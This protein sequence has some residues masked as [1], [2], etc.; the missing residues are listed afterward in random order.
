MFNAQKPSLEELPSSKQL[1]RSTIAAIAAAIV[2]L[3]VVV[4]PAEYG[5]DPTGVGR[6]LGLTEMG[7]IKNEL[8]EEAEQDRNLNTQTGDQ[9]G[10]LRNVFGLFVSSAHAQTGGAWTDEVEFTL[11]PGG[12]YEV[13][14]TMEEGESVDYAMTVTGGRVNFDLHGHGNGNSTTYEKG[15]GSQGSEGT[16]TAAFQGGHGWFWRNRDSTPLTVTLK[17]R[18]TYSDIRKGQ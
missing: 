14:M 10:L 1:L 13:K 6:V 7:E 4:L 11:A 17:L 8:S 16:F 12:T 9:T 3:S 5:I 15:R 18:G 2:I